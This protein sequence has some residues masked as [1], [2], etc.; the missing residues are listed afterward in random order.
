MTGRIMVVDDDRGTLFMV[1]EILKDSGYQVADVEDGFQAIELASKESFALVF[2]DISLP[3]MDGV[4]AFRQIKLVS[5]GT[6]VIMMTGF[7]VEELVCRALSQGAYTVLYEPLDVTSLM[8]A[9]KDVLEGPCVLVFDGGPD[10]Q[11]SIKTKV[12]RLGHQ[13]ALASTWRQ[14]VEH[15]ES[16]QYGVILVNI[17]KPGA[18]GF[19][20]C[21]LIVES[22]ASA[23][24]IFITTHDLNECARQSL[25]AGAFSLVTKPVDP[26]SL[27]ALADS[28]AGATNDGTLG[29]VRAA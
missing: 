16:K 29:S 6:P 21:R 28:F 13:A 19:E 15:V 3:G 12:E 9:A 8:Q 18:E 2:M 1:T 22:D 23:K 7:T 10:I 17:G 24:V 11:E 20:D 27:I 5:P 26:E 25:I 4:E 14:A